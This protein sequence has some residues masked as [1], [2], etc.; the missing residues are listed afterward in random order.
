MILP[1]SLSFLNDIYTLPDIT[2]CWWLVSDFDA[3]TWQ[4]RFNKKAQ[5]INWAIQL[6]D[7]SLLTDPQHAR[8][9]RT[10]KSYLIAATMNYGGRGLTSNAHT[11][12]KIQFRCAIKI[13]DYLLINDSKFEI[14]KYG[15]EGLS[16]GDLKSILKQISSQKDTTESIY[17]WKA[18]LSNFCIELI[19]TT[20]TSKIEEVLSK[21]PEM[22]VVSP[23]QIEQFSL[24]FPI[25]LLTKVRACLFAAELYRRPDHSEYRIHTIKISEIIYKNTLYA[26]TT[27]KSAEES[28]SF[29]AEAEPF[30]REYTAVPVTTGTGI[31]MSLSSFANYRRAMFS[32]ALLHDYDLPVPSM[33][34]LSEICH[35]EFEHSAVGRFRTLPSE[36][37]FNCLR[38][39]IEFHYAH[40]ETLK[41][42]LKRIYLYC[43]T[44]KTTVSTLNE[45]TYAKLNAAQPSA[46]D[47]GL[48]KIGL[49]ARTSGQY[50]KVV[51]SAKNE[52]FEELRKNAGLIEMLR[53][54]IACV[55]VVV[56]TLC[57]RRAGELI[58]LLLKGCLD[59]T[60]SWLIFFLRK[61]TRSVYGIRGAVARPIPSVAVEM[62]ETLSEL[63]DFVGKISGE[64]LQT[65][66]SSPHKS[67]FHFVEASAATFN[68]NLDL[69]CDYFQT[70][71]DSSG[72]RY[73][74][75]Q[76]QFRRFFALLFFKCSNI[77]GL[78][79]LRWM[80]GHTDLQHIWNYI[81]ENIDGAT[82][83]ESKAQYIAEAMVDPEHHNAYED[84]SAL[85]KSEYGVDSHSLV[86]T[87]DLENAILNLIDDERIEVTPVFYNDPKGQKLKVI[88]I[89][90][91]R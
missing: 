68:N 1:D 35:V 34:Y 24:N 33:E 60:K 32:L 70:P 85:I 16:T 45:E 47:L 44:R 27:L 53:I 21:H 71:L 49:S 15:L 22:S 74:V 39:A 23:D 19:S 72:R 81:T 61:S 80:L 89:I 78:D 12:Q 17:S 31:Q 4:Y 18:C 6:S 40:A 13:I 69:F 84:L 29:F 91:E 76:H 58:D 43:S 67:S 54:Y 7:D 62:I 42:S 88:V 87:T 37:V 86:D 77:G 63:H 55:Q 79:T 57:A 82:I 65:L 10:I 28:L 30:E 11:T 83:N 5:D 51:K 26:R 56:G 2:K 41:T 36:V 9:L 48:T 59:E 8:T 3:P 38:N 52:H 75:R 50:H 73:Y 64:S 14:C 46:V 25:E 20:P 90:K 66:F